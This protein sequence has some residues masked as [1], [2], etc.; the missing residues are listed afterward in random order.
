MNLVTDGSLAD[1]RE[2]RPLK[3]AGTTLLLLETLPDPQAFDLNAPDAGTVLEVLLPQLRTLA[4]LI[5]A[6]RQTWD[7]V[8]PSR[9]ADEA[10]W[11]AAR[12]L[13]LGIEEIAL[14]LDKLAMLEVANHRVAEFAVA[15]GLF[16][17]RAMPAVIAKGRPAVLQVVA[18]A[19]EGSALRHADLVTRSRLVAAACV[20][21]L[22]E[23]LR[24]LLG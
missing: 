9:F 7:G 17:R 5:A 1:L 24:R 14:P 12:I 10:D 18:A 23:T 4:L 3:P 2:R 15:H 11:L 6:R 20:A 16:G 8:S 22:P 19:V 21:R 13:L